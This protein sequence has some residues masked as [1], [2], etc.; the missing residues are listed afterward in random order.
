MKNARL[1]RVKKLLV[2]AAMIAGISTLAHALPA[3]DT[4]AVVADPSAG[5]T[6]PPGSIT[7][8]TP[9]QA[10]NQWFY[11][12]A[13][14][15]SNTALV[16][17]I[18]VQFTLNDTDGVV[19]AQAVTVTFAAHGNPAL[20]GSIS[21]TPNPLTT[22][23]D[24][25]PTQSVTI[26]ISTA[27]LADGVYDANVGIAVSPSN[28]ITLDHDTIHIRV[29]VGGAGCD[30]VSSCF[31]TDS[32]FNL[33]SDCAGNPVNTA[34]GGT[35]QIVANNSH[36]IVATNPG[37]FYYNLI[38][39]N[40]TGSSHDITLDLSRLNLNPMATSLA[41]PLHVGVFTSAEIDPSNPL[42]SQ[43]DL[44]NTDGVPCGTGSGGT[45]SCKT[46]VTL[47]PGDILW[48]TWHLTYANIGKKTSS[49][50]LSSACSE[51]L[52]N[53]DGTINATCTVRDSNDLSLLT[54]CTAAAQGYLKH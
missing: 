48:V 3:K 23:T 45:S 8:F 9:G 21:V 22:L 46:T 43:F 24:G 49:L 37:Q 31:L 34:T 7:P 41:N 6:N 11:F 13:C 53:D 4:L 1:V 2:L 50:T 51:T 19:L 54:T 5:T 17:S 12:Y 30:A 25:G 33:L 26:N 42:K 32:A 44:V 28:K 52:L 27:S 35:F 20:A 40:S 38:W 14:L 29:R 39:T 36:T 10:P 16:D 15:P 18:P 47:D